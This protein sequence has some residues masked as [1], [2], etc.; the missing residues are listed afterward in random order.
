MRKDSCD[1]NTM[2]EESHL[3]PWR[4]RMLLLDIHFRDDFGTCIIM[5]VAAP[6]RKLRLSLRNA[7]AIDAGVLE[8]PHE[9]VDRY[10]NKALFRE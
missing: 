5:A 9:E 10:G 7:D 8:D 4:S 1:V 3:V 2:I 6:H